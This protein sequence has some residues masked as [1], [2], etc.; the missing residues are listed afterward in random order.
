MPKKERGAISKVIS[1]KKGGGLEAKQ[2]NNWQ[3]QNEGKER[4]TMRLT[5]K[6][7]WKFTKN[8]TSGKL[9][10]NRKMNWGRVRER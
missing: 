4:K 6:R 2:T 5:S 1:K 3:K 7:K 8:A 9:K 10:E